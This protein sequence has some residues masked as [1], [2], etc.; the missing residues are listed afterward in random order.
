MIKASIVL[1]AP[2]SATGIQPKRP[3]EALKELNQ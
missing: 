2:R 1:P 3:V